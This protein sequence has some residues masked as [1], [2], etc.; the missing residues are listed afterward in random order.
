MDD[1]WFHA[2]VLLAFRLDKALR[3][4]SEH[5]PFVDYYYGPPEWQA[6]AA[7][8]AP[9]PAVRLLAD[10]DN[11]AAAIAR[12]DLEPQRAIFLRK[13]VLAMRTVC[14]KLCGETFTLEDELD[15][16]FDV[17]QPL[18]K[19]PEARF[20]Q[21]WAQAEATLPGS[22]DIQR[23]IEALD[24]HLTLPPE[25]AD[26][27]VE[28]FGRAL[29]EARL[30]AQTFLTL[31][32][33]ESIT[34]RAVR[35]QRWM[36][37]N[38]FQGNA[39]SIIEVNLDTFTYLRSL[40][41]LACHEGYPGH[42]TESTLKERLLYRER[43]QLEQAIGLLISPEEARWMSPT[44]ALWSDVRRNAA[45]L[46]H[47]GRSAA[48]VQEYAQHY[49]RISRKQAEQV[50]AYLQRPFR[51]AY[52]FVDEDGREPWLTARSPRKSPFASNVTA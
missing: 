36:A 13:Q 27:M 18:E 15:R 20:D 47:E 50:L 51:E 9:M 28:L 49:L 7:D 14:Q 23:R 42:H 2:Y 35:G 32:A 38:R 31:P 10:A 24:E 52:I 44:D 3:A 25:R 30:R 1:S 26:A 6:Q 46:L 16:C 22:G 12:L 21:A 11:L 17:R 43:G 5:S 41:T 4:V 29:A 8:E 19:T 37:N 34:V 45:I 39:R 40:L 33:D 48:D